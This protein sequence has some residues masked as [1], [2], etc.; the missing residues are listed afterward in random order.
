MSSTREALL[1]DAVMVDKME[2]PV[3]PDWWRGAVLYEIYWRSFHD[4]DGDGVGDLRG[5]CA[6]LDYIAELGVDAIWLA[7]FYTSPQEDFGY[8]VVDARSV[9]ERAGAMND[10]LELLD[11]AHARGLKVLIDFIPIH[12]SHQHPWFLASRRDQENDRA[13]WY[14][15]ADGAAD[16]GPPNNW[17]SSFGGSAWTWEPRRS[18]YYY[19]PFLPCQPALHLRNR[20]VLDAVLDDMRFWLDHG[21]DGFRL[22]AVQ[23]LA[24]DPSLRS[25]PPTSSDGSPILLGGG[26]HNPFRKQLHLFDRD[27][28]EAIPLIEHM[29][30]VIDSYDGDRVLIGE[31]ADVDSSRAA[32]KYTVNGKRLHAIY[33]FDL[34]NC[35]KEEIPHI[36]KLRDNH[37][38]TG[39]VYNVFT[40]HDSMRALSNMAPLAKTAE[41]RRQAAKMLLFLQFTLKG[42]GAIFQ[43]EELGLA[44]PKLPRHALRDPWGI[45]LWPDFEGRDGVRTPMPW[46]G[47]APHCGFSDAEPWLPIGD[48]HGEAAVDRQT[49]DK[50]SVLRFAR[51]FFRWRKHQ[52]LILHGGE[53][54]LD[55]QAPLIIYDRY[56]GDDRLRCVVNFSLQARLYPY[57]AAWRPLEGP[58][59]SQAA[60]SHGIELPPHGFAALQLDA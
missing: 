10:F 38:R 9:D 19:H 59:C 28:P 33:D 1:A 42:G 16:G 53:R 12:T 8:D 24:C 52:P 6:K 20:E 32:E 56:A 15:W 37:L 7:P 21:V 13:D 40:N 2:P 51:A 30:A 60:S 46:Q 43:G 47:E 22:D 41:Q 3:P 54:M 50:D 58:G 57:D 14:I 55:E 26:P 5:V 11:G 17:L 45:N 36:V 18:Q 23:C 34:I 31:L 39:W 25:N 35:R 27:V 44:Q 29:R 4:S 48:D 49:D